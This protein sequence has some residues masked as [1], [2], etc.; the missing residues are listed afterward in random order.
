MYDTA[1]LND[2]KN[3]FPNIIIYPMKCYKC[4]VLHDKEHC[5]VVTLDL[6]SF[7]QYDDAFVTDNKYMFGVHHK[8]YYILCGS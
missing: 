1:R 5:T 6:C 2:M 7:S 3:N 4:A 8:L